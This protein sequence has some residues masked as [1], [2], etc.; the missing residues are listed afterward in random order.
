MELSEYQQ[1]SAALIA[2]LKEHKDK[3]LTPDDVWQQLIPGVEEAS[4][5][6]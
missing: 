2:D 4:M 3:Y 1:R 5:V 6:P